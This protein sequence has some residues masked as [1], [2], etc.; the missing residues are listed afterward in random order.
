LFHSR[1][2]LKPELPKLCADLPENF[3]KSAC[4]IFHDEAIFKFSNPQLVWLIEQSVSSEVIFYSE[5][6]QQ[7]LFGLRFFRLD[8]PGECERA[9]VFA[10]KRGQSACGFKSGEFNRVGA[11]RSTGGSGSASFRKGTRAFLYWAV[12]RNGNG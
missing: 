5:V 1:H 6:I 3:Q 2:R 8:F 9:A 12:A 11:N 7:N 4:E 10:N